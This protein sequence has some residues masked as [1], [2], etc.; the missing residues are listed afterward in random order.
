MITHVDRHANTIIKLLQPEVEENWYVTMH[1]RH[2]TKPGDLVF[3]KK[4]NPYYNDSY[5]CHYLEG[6]FFGIVAFDSTNGLK[7]CFIDN[8]FLSFFSTDVA[9]A[10]VN[11]FR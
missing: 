8:R 6:D 11:G 3:F 2:L 5:G 9:E 1:K 10:V 4:G 7:T